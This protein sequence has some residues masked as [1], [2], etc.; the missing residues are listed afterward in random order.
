[1]RSMTE[2]MGRVNAEVKV[3]PFMRAV[4]GC[5]PDNRLVKR[6]VLRWSGITKF[7]A[8]LGIS[9]THLSRV[10]HGER[11][12]GKALDKRMRRIGLTPGSAA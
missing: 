10:M 11:K 3:S 2:I 1:M 12:P 8:E 7:A 4:A 6:Q 9:R 5:E